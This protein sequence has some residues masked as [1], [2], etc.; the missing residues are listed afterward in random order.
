MARLLFLFLAELPFLL[1][2]ES[3]PLGGCLRAWKGEALGPFLTPG[4]K[5]I[6]LPSEECPALW[7][8]CSF[9]TL[10]LH[11]LFPGFVYFEWLNVY[12]DTCMS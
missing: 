2:L 9:A 4:K 10:Q 7:G 8:L 1:N 11:G 5:S 12:G 6:A 3:R